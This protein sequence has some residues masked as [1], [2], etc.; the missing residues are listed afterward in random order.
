MYDRGKTNVMN[1]FDIKNQCEFVLAH[2][3]IRLQLLVHKIIK[4]ACFEMHSY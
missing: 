3:G 2:K 1:Q 4:K